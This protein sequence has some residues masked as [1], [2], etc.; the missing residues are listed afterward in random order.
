MHQVK[1]G[2]FTVIFSGWLDQA[3][4]LPE[5]VVGRGLEVVFVVN[6]DGSFYLFMMSALESRADGVHRIQLPDTAAVLND[7]YANKKIVL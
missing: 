7:I 3:K 2:Y 5:G 4:A 1:A 6:P